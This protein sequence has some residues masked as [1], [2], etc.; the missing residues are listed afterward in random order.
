[1][2]LN[3]KSKLLRLRKIS[4]KNKTLKKD[5]TKTCFC[6]LSLKSI[7]IKIFFFLMILIY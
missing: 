3:E 1:M 6:Y 4:Y 5:E 7:L 2:N